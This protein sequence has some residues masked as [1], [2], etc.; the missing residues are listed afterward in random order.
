MGRRC[1]VAVLLAAVT[2]A[3]A[4][5]LAQESTSVGF[6]VIVHPGNALPSIERPRLE[7]AFLKKTR[8]WPGG[9]VIQPV[10]LPQSSS[11]RRQF[12]RQVL[13]RS[14]EAVRA[15]WQQRIF[16]GR[17]LPPPELASDQEV[18]KYVSR[19]RGAVGYV[20]ADLPVTGVRALPI[21]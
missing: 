10:D 14:L 9:E 7:D 4:T 6:V 12:T 18:V 8:T 1:L 17:D 15:Y 19:N 3:S 11:V 20:R 2:T 21:H 16:S 13:R 5:L